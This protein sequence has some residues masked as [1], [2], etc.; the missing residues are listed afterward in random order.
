M[1]KAGYIA[2]IGRPNAGKSTLLNSIIETKLSIVTPKKQTTRK[3]VIGIYSEDET[4]IVFVDTPGIIKPKYELHRAMMKFVEESMKESDA[5]LFILDAVDFIKREDYFH[6][7]I[8]D[9]LK[10][11]KKR[12]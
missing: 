1:T 9:L 2:I 12:Y 11:S 8:I 5:L 6:E 3:R 4:Q 7:A 10:N